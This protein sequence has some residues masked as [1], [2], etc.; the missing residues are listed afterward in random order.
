MNYDMK[1]ALSVIAMGVNVL[2]ARL[3]AL[4]GILG[5]VALT[6]YAM[7]LGTWEAVVIGCLY[8]VVVLLPVFSK[9][10]RRAKE[11]EGE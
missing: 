10:E 6:G 1:T 5:A 2:A 8:D 9:G 11:N 4:L 3:L 7:W